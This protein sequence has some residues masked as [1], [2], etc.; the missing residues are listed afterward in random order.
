[1]T[2]VDLNSLKGVQFEVW[3][4]EWFD[5]CLMTTFQ[6]SGHTWQ[7]FV[8]INFGNCGL[9]LSGGHTDVADGRIN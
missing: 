5:W 3:V 1:M 9:N 4:P 8:F 6:S 7:S 2:F